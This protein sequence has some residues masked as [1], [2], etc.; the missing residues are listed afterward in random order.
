M[1]SEIKRILKEQVQPFVAMHRGSIEFVS[2]DDGVV[3][4]RLAG[5]CKGCPLSQLTLKEGVEVILKENLNGVDRVE[6]VE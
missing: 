6:A 4:V 2:F 5:T 1:E 3:S